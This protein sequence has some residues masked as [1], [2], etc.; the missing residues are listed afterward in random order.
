MLLSSLLLED[1][2]FLALLFFA[3]FARMDVDV[4]PIRDFCTIMI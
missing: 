4:I 2:S 3:F 1:G